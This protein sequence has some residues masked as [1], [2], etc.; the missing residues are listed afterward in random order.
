M[1]RDDPGV[2]TVGEIARHAGLTQPRLTRLFREQIGI[3]MLDYRNQQRLQRAI[4]LY[5]PGQRFTLQQVADTAGFTSYGHFHRV[6]K[7]WM[8]ISPADYS[9][10]VRNAAGLRTASSQAA[11]GMAP[12]D[13]VAALLKGGRAPMASGVVAG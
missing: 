5:G 2:Q 12:P 13:R 7:H 9:R 6:F 8:G 10:T 3:S 11:P 1:I 4:K